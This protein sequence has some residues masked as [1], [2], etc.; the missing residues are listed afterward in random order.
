LAL[1]PATRRCR[2]GDASIELTAREFGLL[3]ALMRRPGVVVSKLE[4]LDEVWGP[5]FTGDPNI[6]E[7]YVGYL[8][9]K[10]DAPFACTTLQ[11]VR[12]AGYRAVAY[13]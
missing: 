1:D 2:R 13:A 3:E 7:V 4:L 5:D 12:G 6:V 9:R 11:T 8:R 10:I